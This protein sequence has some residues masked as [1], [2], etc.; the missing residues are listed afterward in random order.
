MEIIQNFWMNR[1]VAMEILKRLQKEYPEVR[2]TA[3]RFEN[4]FQLLVATILSAQSTDTQVNR[5]TE[6]L[7]KKYRGP[8]DFLR[9]SQEELERDL[10]SVGL[11]KNKARFIKEA[12]RVILEEFDGKVP[13]SMEELLKLPGVGRKTANVVLSN[14]F[15]RHEGIAVD[16]H[17]MRLSRRIG[18]SGKERREEIEEDLMKL[19]PREFWGMISNLLIAHGRRV[20]RA[21]RP[22]CE[23]CVISEFCKFP[24][25]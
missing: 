19:Y 1:E 10:S 15:G 18:L 11:Y 6:R 25:R 7:F 4:P 12:S 22:L 8:E 13:E 2:S 16:T 14:A 17:V 24:R 9:A 23:N 3:L 20:C 5:I 21:R